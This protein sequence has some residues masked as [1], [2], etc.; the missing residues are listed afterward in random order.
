MSGRADSDG[1]VVGGKWVEP[2]GRKRFTTINPATGEVVGTFLA[3]HEED[4]RHAV[5]AAQKAFPA[6]RDTPAPRR[7]EILL[8]V[9]AYLKQHKEEI[10]EV[11][12]REMG[13]VIS[14]CRGDFKESIDLL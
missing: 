3:A 4:V 14:E 6:W 10:A 5:D 8:E 7:G 13:K 2:S 9:A 12:T 11:V 1:L